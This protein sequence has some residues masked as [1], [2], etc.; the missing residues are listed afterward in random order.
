MNL[1]FVVEA[2]ALL[3]CIESRHTAASNWSAVAALVDGRVIQ[4][5]RNNMNG[6]LQQTTTDTWTVLGLNPSLCSEK[7]ASIPNGMLILVLFIGDRVIDPREVTLLVEA[8]ET[9]WLPRIE[10][11]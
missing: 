7:P 5:W 9:I 6:S 4:H 1:A 11:Q 3:G 8:A 10:L 2:S